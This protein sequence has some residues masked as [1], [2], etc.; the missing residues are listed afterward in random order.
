MLPL[1]ATIGHCLVLLAIQLYSW[2]LRMPFQ[3]RESEFLA[4]FLFGMV[5]FPCLITGVFLFFDALPQSRQRQLS[6]AWAIIGMNWALIFQMYFPE[7][8]GW[9]ELINMT[10]WAGY[11][12]MLIGGIWAFWEDG[13]QAQMEN[14]QGP[15]TQG[16]NTQGPEK[17]EDAV[18]PE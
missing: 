4:P 5:I 16:S 14:T 8:E 2:F 9:P 1:G 15:D 17:S 3:H 18:Q 10:A 12:G 7:P 11:A 6:A 13:G